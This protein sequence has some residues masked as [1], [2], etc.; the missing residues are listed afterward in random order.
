TIFTGLG[1]N[2]NELGYN[3]GA[4]YHF[5]SQKIVSAYVTAMYGY[6]VVLIVKAL[7][8]ESKTTYFGPSAGAGM[9]IA[10]QNKSFLSLELLMPFRPQAYQNAID[11][12]KVL[13]YEMKDPLPFGFGVGY[14]IRF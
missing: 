6:N 1:Y 7:E 5:P 4:Q 8:T 10:F 11:D 9:Q 12:L 14:H 13:G 3:V 2:L